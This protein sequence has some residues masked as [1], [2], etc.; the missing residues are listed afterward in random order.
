MIR[1]QIAATLAA[2]LLVATAFFPSVSRAQSATN[3]QDTAKTRAT[4]QKIGT[5]RDAGVEVKL[6]DKTKLKGYIS[7]VEQ[8]SFTLTD[9]KTGSAQTLSYA[10]VDQ[11]KKQHGGLSTRGWLVIAAVAAGVV[12]TAIAVKPAVCDGGAQNRFPC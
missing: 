8:D 5:G 10:E 2:I 3:L 9:S 11:V 4:V 12:I 1:K 7:A 6:R